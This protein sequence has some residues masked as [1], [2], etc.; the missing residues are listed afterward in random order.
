[1]R[2]RATKTND[3]HAK[4]EWESCCE[5][6]NDDPDEAFI[7]ET[8]LS[9]RPEKLAKT[10]VRGTVTQFAPGDDAAA[11]GA[12]E[13]VT[14]DTMVQHIHFDDR[15]SA[16]DV[17][18]KLVAVNASDIGAMGAKPTWAVLS[19]SLPNPLDRSWVTQFSEGMGEALKQWDIHLVG[20]DTTGSPGPITASMTL[21]GHTSQPVC[22]SGAR[23]G[24][25]LWVTGRLGEAASGFLYGT[26]S[27]LSALRRPCPPVAFGAALAKSVHVHAMMDISDGLARDLGRMCRASKVSAVVD[28]SALLPGPGLL[29]VADPLA[30]QVA[31]GEDYQLLFAAAPEDTAKIQQTAAQHRIEVQPIGHFLSSRGQHTARLMDMPWPAP[32]FSHFQGAS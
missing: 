28:P 9:H 3:H 25:F 23:S 10:A 22:R 16:Q 8:L 20:G 30:A 17:G 29:E 4:I 7:I 19:L 27:G 21:A 26:K 5:V 31:F 13:V 1:M 11:V 32:A 24:D 18:W 12:S 6:M 2:K 14:V 15:L